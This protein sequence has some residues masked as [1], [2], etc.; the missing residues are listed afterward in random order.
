MRAYV[1]A[2]NNEIEIIKFSILGWLTYCTVVYCTVLCILL[3][4]FSFFRSDFARDRAYSCARRH[5][6]NFV[7][8]VCQN[9]FAIICNFENISNIYFAQ[10]LPKWAMAI[11]PI[12]LDLI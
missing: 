7:L 1:M 6:I 10:I 11:L 3:L 4:M 8:F 12:V 9:I 2:R 5:C